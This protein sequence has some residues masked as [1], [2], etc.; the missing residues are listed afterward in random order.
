MIHACLA[1][2]VCLCRNG[3]TFAEHPQ[4]PIRGATF[5]SVK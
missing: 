5:Q 1:L 3:H 4:P 2:A